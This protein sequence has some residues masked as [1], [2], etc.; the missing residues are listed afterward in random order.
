MSGAIKLES[1]LGKSK[2]PRYESYPE[3][4][5]I[6]TDEDNIRKVKVSPKY[7]ELG[8]ILKQIIEHEIRNDKE[9]KRNGDA[10]LK[11]FALAFSLLSPLDKKVQNRVI[12]KLN[13]HLQL[14]NKI[15]KSE[16]Q[17]RL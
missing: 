9:R 12:S 6:V 10:E 3:W 17:L 2:D 4:Y 14:N 5:F 16:R 11:A 8:N 7:D 15:D 13:L 1:R